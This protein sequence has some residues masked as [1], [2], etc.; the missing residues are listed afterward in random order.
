MSV[1]PSLGASWIYAF[2][3]GNKLKR[4]ETE[5]KNGL[6]KPEVGWIQE[7]RHL[8]LASFHEHAGHNQ[9][10]NSH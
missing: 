4:R 7:G 10:L 8:E 3:S 9:L 2:D 1:L 5:L 6:Q